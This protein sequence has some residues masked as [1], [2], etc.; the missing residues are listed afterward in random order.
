MGRIEYHLLPLDI[1]RGGSATFEVVRPG[2]GCGL[3][4]TCNICIIDMYV[5]K[6]IMDLRSLFNM[7]SFATL[8]KYNLSVSS[9]YT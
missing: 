1:C 4:V 8:S 3:R 9:L 2:S 6:L 7:D 5:T